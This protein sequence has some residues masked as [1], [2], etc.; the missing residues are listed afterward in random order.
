M[1]WEKFYAQDAKTYSFESLGCPE[2]RVTM[3]DAR[4]LPYGRIRQIQRLATE[5]ERLQAAGEEVPDE[6]I[7]RYM[8]TLAGLIVYW[9]LTDPETKQPLPVPTPHDLSSFDR[10]PMAFIE[11]LQGFMNSAMSS[12]DED[13]ALVPQPSVSN[14]GLGS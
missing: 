13:D 1:S 11:A 14:S 9:N 5:Q 3:R 7:D 10:L 8:A 2:F 12:G 4:A 6:L